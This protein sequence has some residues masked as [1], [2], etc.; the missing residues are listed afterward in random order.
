MAVLP[1]HDELI[2]SDAPPFTQAQL[3]WLAACQY[4]TAIGA[5]VVASGLVYNVW[6]FLIRQARYKVLPLVTFYVLALLLMSERVYFAIWFFALT[7]KKNSVLWQTLPLTI[8]AMIAVLQSWMI[9][10]LCI[11]L[12]QSY[13][14]F[15]SR[16]ERGRAS[17]S[18]DKCI[19]VGRVAV[20]VFIV[21][22]ILTTTVLLAFVDG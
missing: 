11:R 10:E 18:I 20:V 17:T 6:K 14:E 2:G 3:Q 12:H 13:K 1:Y 9:T 22:A 21:A 7:Y 19:S 8:K 5:L 4:L 16:G 15:S